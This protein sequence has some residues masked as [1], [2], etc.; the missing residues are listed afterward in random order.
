MKNKLMDLY[1]EYWNDFLSLAGFAS[2]RGMTEA[3][4]E[5]VINIGRKLWNRRA[6]KLQAEASK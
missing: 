1:G 4:A 5:R 3:K 2:Y 6:A